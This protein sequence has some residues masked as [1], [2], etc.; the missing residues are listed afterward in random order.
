M[1]KREDAGR[2]CPICLAVDDPAGMI[3]VNIERT[4]P[5]DAV[6]VHFCTRCARAITAAT[7]ENDLPLLEKEKREHEPD[8]T[9]ENRLGSIGDQPGPTDRE[10]L[11]SSPDAPAATGDPGE[12]GSGAEIPE[13]D[14]EQGPGSLRS[15]AKKRD[16]DVAG[17]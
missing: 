1:P 13:V 15:G 16:T 12:L 2:C 8:A 4:N 5:P 11:E 14:P 7:I 17:E 9:S 6:V 10:R 3:S